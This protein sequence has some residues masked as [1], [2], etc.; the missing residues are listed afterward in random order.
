L[1]KVIEITPSNNGLDAAKLPEIA[2][3]VGLD[4][5]AFNTCLSN[6]E[7]AEIVDAGIASAARAGAQGTPY[8]LVV[9]GGEIV[10]VINGAQPYEIVK[11]Q[12]DELLK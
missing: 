7:T 10:G 5:V 12:I 3:E 6:G 4:V 8:S 9:V 1:N 2:K 11:A